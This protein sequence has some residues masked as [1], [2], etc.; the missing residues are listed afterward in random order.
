MPGRDQVFCSC[1]HNFM[2]RA[3]EWEHRARLA[4]L[5]VNP[6]P[7]T[8][9]PAIRQIFNIDV[10]DKDSEGSQDAMLEDEDGL[11]ADA[12]AYMAEAPPHAIQS[13]EPLEI[14]D[15]TFLS[16]WYQERGRLW[17]RD[18]ESSSE[19]GSS[20]AEN[21]DERSNNSDDDLGYPN[22]D[23]YDAGSGLSAWDQLGEDYENTVAS[24][25]VFI[26]FVFD[27]DQ[28]LILIGLSFD[29]SFTR[30]KT[31]QL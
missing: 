6:G 1:C 18:A 26:F 22:W 24:A 11:G 3:R 23:D 8:S 28:K 4:I 30:R 29:F 19:S 17:H 25:G 5:S 7:T 9:T 27:L 21:D 20:G 12:D 16:D 13:Q 2:T 14:L 31:K 15:A 10:S